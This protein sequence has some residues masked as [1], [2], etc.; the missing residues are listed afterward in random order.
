[1]GYSWQVALG[2]VF[3]AAMGCFMIAP[4]FIK[5]PRQ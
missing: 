3:I 5:A 1:M 4:D 2:A